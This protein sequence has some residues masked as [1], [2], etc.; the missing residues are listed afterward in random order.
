MI[1]SFNFHRDVYE[2]HKKFDIPIEKYPAFPIEELLEFRIKFMR[3]EVQEFEEAVS[4]NDIGCAFDALIDIV[5]VA[6]GTAIMM[7]V[8]FNQGWDI[9][10]AANMAKVR[11]K[12]NNESKRGST[13]DVVKPP[14]W[15]APDMMLQ[16]LLLKHE[17]ELRTNGVDKE[18]NEE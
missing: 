2:F 8:P 3:E 16:S 15:T 1:M 9:V 18:E 4:R 6:L 12:T 10:H 7:N 5:Y 14:N 11:A 13:F 17:Y